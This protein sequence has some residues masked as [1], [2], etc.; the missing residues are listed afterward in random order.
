VIADHRGAVEGVFD[1]FA[2]IVAEGKAAATYAEEG[3]LRMGDGP[4]LTATRA[5]RWQ[6]S[7]DAVAVFF[8]DGRPFHNFRLDAGEVA[9]EH[10][11]GADL[12]RVRY[13]F[14][15]WPFWTARWEVQ[16]PRK[17]YAMESQY[18]RVNGA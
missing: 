1:G 5:Y 7:E 2:V 9:A 14:A 13:D 8:V 11:C 6:F 16:G 18:R 4:Q 17:D 15:G 3:L 12:Y 10:L